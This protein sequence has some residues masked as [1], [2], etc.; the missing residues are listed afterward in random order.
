MGLGP[1]GEL[2]ALRRAPEAG[3]LAE[4]LVERYGGVGRAEGADD[5]GGGVGCYLKVAILDRVGGVSA[6]VVGIVFGYAVLFAVVFVGSALGQC[7]RLRF[8]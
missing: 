3:R 1:I 5:G 6:V 8:G 2:D 4:Y 7:C